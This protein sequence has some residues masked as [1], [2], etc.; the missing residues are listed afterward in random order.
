MLGVE[1]GKAVDIGNFSVSACV[2]T[3]QLVLPEVP[4]LVA[5]IT[6]KFYAQLD[7]LSSEILTSGLTPPI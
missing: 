4:R 2:T 7:I 5:E 1:V 3:Q 6:G